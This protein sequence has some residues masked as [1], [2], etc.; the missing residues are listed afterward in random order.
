MPQ[1]W[2]SELDGGETDCWI[3]EIQTRSE[4]DFTQLGFE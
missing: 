3:V 4:K 1:Y 2:E